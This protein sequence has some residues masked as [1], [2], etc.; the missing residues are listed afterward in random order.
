MVQLLLLRVTF[1]T[2][3]LFHVRAKN[4]Y[5]VRTHV[6]IT[7]QWK[8]A[9]RCPPRPWLITSRLFWLPFFKHQQGMRV[10]DLR[11]RTSRESSLLPVLP[12]VA[13]VSP[14]IDHVRDTANAAHKACWTV[15]ATQSVALPQALFIYYVFIF[16][17]IT[18]GDRTWIYFT[19]MILCRSRIGG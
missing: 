15:C 9:L 10:G 2:L 1:H 6:K 11:A 18:F 3:P 19:V 5:Y 16:P 14:V 17:F 13:I 12:F 4:L 7:Q 8:S